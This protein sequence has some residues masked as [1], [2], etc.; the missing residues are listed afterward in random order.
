MK[1]RSA[2]VIVIGGGIVG[3]STAY[4]LAKRGQSVI[5]LE[6]GRV[7]E[8]ASGRNGGGVRQ[9]NRHPGELPI[10]M[11]GIKTI[12]GTFKEEFDWDVEYRVGGYIRLITSEKEYAT[13]RKN[14]KWQQKMGLKIEFLTA[15]ETRALVPSIP[16]HIEL[17]GSTY[18]PTD[19]T[20]NPL[21]V[22]KAIA[23]TAKRLGAQIFEH[24]PV[25]GLKVEGG[26]VVAAITDQGDY[27]GHVFVNMAGPWS[28]TIC[29]W[30]GLD[31]PV[32]NK[33]AQ[34]WVTEP[35]PPL[36]KEFVSFDVGYTRQALNGGFHLGTKSKSVENYDKSSTFESFLE[37]G[38]RMV[39]IFPFFKEVSILRSW[40]G[41]NDWPPDEIPIID[42]APNLEGFFMA[43][44]FSGHGFCTGPMIG[45]LMT[46]WILDG[47]SSLDLSA[48]RWTRFD[49]IYL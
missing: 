14:L 19:G 36:I 49:K 41:I 7:G 33:R 9:S 10:A 4:N 20:A 30:V 34:V 6:K 8:E 24:E 31:F 38:S 22:T 5:L 29:N 48:F 26:R 47:K 17:M 11:E 39:E 3:C 23:R 44:G 32:N 35:L 15:E 42:K 16:K 18:C 28:K 1:I 21:L 43:S 25:K 45:K 37:A 2:D 27:R 12:W 40:G 13:F 46:K